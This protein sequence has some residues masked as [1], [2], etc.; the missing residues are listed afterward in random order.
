M[1][2][3]GQKSVFEKRRL[4]GAAAVGLG[5][6]GAGEVIAAVRGGS[7]LDGLGRLAADYAPVPVVETMVAR[8]GRHDKE[9]TR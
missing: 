4:L 6:L 1:S 2:R 9:M 7:L 8:S 3:N 5:A